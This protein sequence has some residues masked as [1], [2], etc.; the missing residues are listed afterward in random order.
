MTRASAFPLDTTEF[1]SREAKLFPEIIC[2]VLARAKA[3]ILSF[4]IH[5]H[6]S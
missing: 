5:M 6:S 4:V 2:F 3:H 1:S